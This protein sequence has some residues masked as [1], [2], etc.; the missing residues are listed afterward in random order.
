MQQVYLKPAV[1]ISLF[2]FGIRY[3]GP[4]A[5][6][7]IVTIV[8]HDRYS[9]FSSSLPSI[10]ISVTLDFRHRYPRFYHRYLRYLPSLSTRSRKIPIGPYW[11]LSTCGNNIWAYEVYFWLIFRL[12]LILLSNIVTIYITNDVVL[13]IFTIRRTPFFF[14]II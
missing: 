4:C 12:S 5:V 2:E 3:V 6:G 14:I 10:F 1:V 13:R 11:I 9:R 7:K 8:I